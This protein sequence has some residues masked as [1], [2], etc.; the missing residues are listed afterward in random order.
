MR[1]EVSCLP[2]ATIFNATAPFFKINLH[3][4]GLIFFFFNKK[5]GNNISDNFRFPKEKVHSV[6]T[7]EVICANRCFKFVNSLITLLQR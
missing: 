1:C 2:L 7:P 5:E 3:R 4:F 6:D